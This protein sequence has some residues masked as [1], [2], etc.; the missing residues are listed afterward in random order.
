MSHESDHEL[1]VLTLNPSEAEHLIIR[2]TGKEYGIISIF[3][4]IVLS[5]A[6]PF[7]DHLYT[8]IGIKWYYK[9]GTIN[10]GR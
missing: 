8:G 10:A 1:R 9:L 7:S 6:A 3:S 2:F 5:L 4:G